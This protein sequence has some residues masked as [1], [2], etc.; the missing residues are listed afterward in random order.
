MNIRYLETYIEVVKQKSLSEAARSLYLTQPA[1]SFQI[2]KLEHDLGYRLLDR[3]K[4]NF[5][6]TR[7]GKRFFRFA[8]YV[9]Q[10]HK[11]LLYDLR[12][13]HE[14]I[15]G[16]LNIVSNSVVGEF[17]LP[18]ILSEFK[19]HNPS[20]EIKLTIADSFTAIDQAEKGFNTIGFGAVMIEK[21]TLEYVKVAEDEIVL[22]VYPGHPFSN[23]KE[24]MVS[25][26]TG[27]SLIL[28]YEPIG[29]RPSFGTTLTK[30][31]L[32][33]DQ[34]QPKLIL[35]TTTGVISAVEAKSGVALMSY[36]TVRNSEAM[37]LVKVIRI[38][39]FEI[40]RD[41]FCIYRK[42]ADANPIVISFVEFIKTHMNKGQ[43]S[44]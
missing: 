30:A 26:L 39:N 25:D 3:G 2:Q 24:V 42:G 12:Q 8:E 5:S 1:I 28:R 29:M 13:M 9:Y 11:N 32:D 18:P 4:N 44:I 36:Q 40:K 35:G 38:K 27:E 6:V 16:N 22:I 43:S 23:Q 21:A 7:E 33:L 20:I 41:L 14:G 15:I 19:E 34:Y 37:G 31:G 10:E 17:L